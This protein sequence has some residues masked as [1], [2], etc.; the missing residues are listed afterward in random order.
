VDPWLR[1]LAAFD[2]DEIVALEHAD[3]QPGASLALVAALAAWAG[4]AKPDLL[5]APHSYTARDYMPRLASRLQRPLVTDCQS[6]RV[7]DGR[8]VFTRPI[9]QGKLVADVMVEGPPPHL[10]T[11]QS[12]AATADMVRPAT[13]AAMISRPVV[14]VASDL[15]NPVVEAP[16]REVARAVDLARVDRIVAAGRGIQD[17][18]HLDLIRNLAAALG[19][20]VAASRPVC[21]AGWL[22]MDRQIGSSGQTVAPRLY[23]AIGISGAIQH[24]VGM[25][26]AQTIV[27]INK[28]PRAPIFEIA[29][30][31]VVGDLFEIVPALVSALEREPRA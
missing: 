10:V 13:T 11:L 12:R 23:V 20:E 5:L 31:G 28:D 7:V 19:A 22:P 29:D 8:R 30:Y 4:D 17:A 15:P 18:R 26:G 9:F 27:A 2:L 24:I 6:V 1:D 21:D 25:K 16:F 3:L 14:S